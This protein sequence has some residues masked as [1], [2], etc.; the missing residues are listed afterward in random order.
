M[1]TLRERASRTP[2]PEDDVAVDQL[3][4]IRAEL[5]RAPDEAI[6]T[7]A[8]RA[9]SDRVTKLEELRNRFK[10]HRFDAVSPSS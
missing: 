10:E 3:T 2:N 7:E 6:A 4:V 5:P 8:E 1:R 9:Q